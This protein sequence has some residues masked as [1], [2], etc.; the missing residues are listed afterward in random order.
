MH[1]ATDRRQPGNTPSADQRITADEIAVAGG[2]TSPA[3]WRQLLT[4]SATLLRPEPGHIAG[5][6]ASE[7]AA[8][9]V[10]GA[11]LSQAIK[12]LGYVIVN[13]R[14]HHKNGRTYPLARTMIIPPTHTPAEECAALAHHLAHIHQKHQPRTG[15]ACDGLQ[16]LAA[17]SVAYLVC[18]AARIPTPRTRFDQAELLADHG[19][20]PARFIGTII[21]TTQ[22]ILSSADLA[23]SPPSG[24]QDNGNRL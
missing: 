22:Y 17:T 19:D 16:E 15:V 21:A 2:V 9:N 5:G 4:R 3:G 14:S 11:Q 6:V 13:G 20:G 12:A 1:P 10:V 23:A 18:A 7:L 8:A 24:S